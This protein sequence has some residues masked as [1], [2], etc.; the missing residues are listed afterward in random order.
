M[1]TCTTKK[2]LRNEL[3]KLSVPNVLKDMVY[4]NV[5][6]GRTY[7]PGRG[8]RNQCVHSEHI[9]GHGD[10]QIAGQLYSEMS[11]AALERSRSVELRNTISRTAQRNIA[12]NKKKYGVAVS[13]ATHC[14][15]RIAET[16]DGELASFGRAMAAEL[17][18]VYA[19]V[20]RDA[21]IAA[22]R[23]RREREPGDVS[24]DPNRVSGNRGASTP[25]HSASLAE[26]F[27]SGAVRLYR[28]EQKMARRED[29]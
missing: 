9:P 17:V 2:E 8:K 14:A 16:F 21:V 10:F 4:D 1:I 27:D 23:A 13:D 7:T 22:E 6:L 12:R 20:Q 5:V 15:L 29:S 18:A 28:K 25:L 24:G 19:S 11:A 3:D 26:E